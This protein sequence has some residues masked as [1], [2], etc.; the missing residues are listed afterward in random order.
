MSKRPF[1]LPATRRRE[2]E[3]F[4]REIDVSDTEDFRRFLIAWVWHNPKSKDPLGA[5]MM[6]AK[7]MGGQI[8]EAQAS[9]VIEEAAATPKLRAAD[10][11]GKYLRLTEMLRTALRIRTIGSID[12][13]KKQRAKRRKELKRALERMSRRRGGAKTRIEYLAAHSLSR[14][15]PWL[16]NGISRRTWYRRGHKSVDSHASASA[17]A[18]NRTAT[19]TGTACFTAPPRQGRNPDSRLTT[20]PMAQVRGHYKHSRLST[21][22]CHMEVGGIVHG[23]VPR[24]GRGR[25]Q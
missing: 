17:L 1:D 21:D 23:L 12:V 10:V 7:R 13:L 8:S 20:S 6:A 25:L 4:A 14:Q 22:L 3:R 2:I 9:S 11:L 18:Q 16:A 24:G 19:A 15:K 5:L